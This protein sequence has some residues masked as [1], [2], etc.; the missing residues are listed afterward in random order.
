MHR[1]DY[2]RIPI[3][4]IPQEIIDVYNLLPLV[5][6]EYIS[7]RINKGMYGLPQAGRIANDLLAKQL[8]KFGY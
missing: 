3:E 5:H 7:I 1:P 4:L 8:A 2:M 6:N